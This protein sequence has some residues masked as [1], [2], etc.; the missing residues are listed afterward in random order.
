M[1]CVTCVLVGM[2]MLCGQNLEAANPGRAL[3]RAEVD[4]A[5]ESAIR[6]LN[7]NVNPNSNSYL[8]Q[9]KMDPRFSHMGIGKRIKVDPY[10]FVVGL[11]KRKRVSEEDQGDVIPMLDESEYTTDVRA[12]D[13]SRRTPGDGAVSS[14]NPTSREASYADTNPFIFSRLVD[15]RKFAA[16]K[17]RVSINGG[18][19]Q[20]RLRRMQQRLEPVL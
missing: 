9:S 12:S 3:T 19:R 16:P 10:N 4:T 13:D 14:L 18:S 17:D 8:R 5:M 11:G 15:S 2:C 20:L 1:D 6:Q 7:A